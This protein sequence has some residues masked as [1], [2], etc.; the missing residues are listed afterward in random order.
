MNAENEQNDKEIRILDAAL[1]LFSRYGLKKTSIE[2]IAKTA[3]LGKGTIYL[4]FRS[5]EDIFEAVG[6]RFAAALNVALRQ[7]VE[8]VTGPA[9][10]V[11]QYILTR[12]HFVYDVIKTNGLTAE[13]FDEASSSSAMARVRDH[14]GAEQIALLQGIIE[15]GVAAGD[16]STS[17]P[18][19]SALAIFVAMDCLE[20]PWVC[21]GRELNLHDKVQA[22]VELYLVGLKKRPEA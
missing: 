8:K 9:Q 17:N 5:K 11:H 14:F 21:Q 18:E 22:L 10:K 2:D 3:G 1:A 12:F 16:F 6:R 19:V 4:Y 20:K 15:E 13:I 7:E